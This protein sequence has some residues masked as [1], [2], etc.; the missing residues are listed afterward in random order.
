MFMFVFISGCIAQ[1]VLTHHD[2]LIVR[3]VDVFPC[4]CVFMCFCLFVVF[5]VI[6]DVV[7]KCSDTS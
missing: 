3:A 6:V 1:R 7:M 4:L 5:Y 2:V